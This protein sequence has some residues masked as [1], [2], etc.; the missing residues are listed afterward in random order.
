MKFK[1]IE[2]EDQE[3]YLVPKEDKIIVDLEETPNDIQVDIVKIQQITTMRVNTIGVKYKDGTPVQFT[4]W[5]YDSGRVE[6][7]T[8]RGGNYSATESEFDLLEAWYKKNIKK[9]T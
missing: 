4:R 5:E 6:W 8:N 1:T 2:V 7:I 3:Y 9:I